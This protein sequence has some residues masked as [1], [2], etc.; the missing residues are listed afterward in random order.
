MRQ[1][2]A[3][4]VRMARFSVVRFVVFPIKPRGI[5]FALEEGNQAIT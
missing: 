1:L 3:Q 4:R 2:H 5:V